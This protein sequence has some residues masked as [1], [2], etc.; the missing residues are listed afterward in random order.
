MNNQNEQKSDPRSQAAYEVRNFVDHGREMLVHIPTDRTFPRF[1]AVINVNAGCGPGLP[2]IQF[3]EL[4]NLPVE[5]PS[6][7]TGDYL[8]NTTGV[9]ALVTEAFKQWEPVLKENNA[10][11]QKK[12]QMIYEARFRD[13]GAPQGIVDGLGNV[14]SRP[15]AGG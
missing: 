2:P 14:V 1:M 7:W 5:K 12:A 6:I 15:K 13:R 4:L 10:R 11:I 3:I 9:Q 8:D